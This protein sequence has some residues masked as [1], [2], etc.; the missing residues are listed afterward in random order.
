MGWWSVEQRPQRVAQM[1]RYLALA[2]VGLEMVAP[3]LLGLWLD[4]EWG[5]GPWLTVGGAVL[6]LVVGVTHLVLLVNR[7]TSPGGQDTDERGRDRR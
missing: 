4:A 5:T 3:I 1:G 2:Q 7:M 6:G